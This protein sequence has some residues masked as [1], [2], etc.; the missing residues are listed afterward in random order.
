MLPAV[1]ST[2]GLVMFCLCQ[3]SVRIVCMKHI[4]TALHS[5]CAVYSVLH[6]VI[7]CSLVAP[8]HVVASFLLCLL[9][10]RVCL[11]HMFF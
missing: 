5:G 8:Q 1:E 3:E 9:L 10:C 6:V 11:H 7:V 4:C 2:I